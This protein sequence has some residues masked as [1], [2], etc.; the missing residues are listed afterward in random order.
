[1]SLTP[2]KRTALETALKS[3]KKN[4]RGQT[5]FFPEYHFEPVERIP[6]LFPQVNEALGGGVL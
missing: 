1:M 6:L 4:Y 3:I 2:E 5:N